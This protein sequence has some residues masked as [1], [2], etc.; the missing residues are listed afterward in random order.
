MNET[1][2]IPAPPTIK[3]CACTRE[4]TAAEWEAL[5]LIGI[6]D[7][8]DGEEFAELRNCAC[9]STMAILLPTSQIAC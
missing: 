3:T 1:T 6:Q 7:C 2:T 9:G 4:Y 8:G 5:K